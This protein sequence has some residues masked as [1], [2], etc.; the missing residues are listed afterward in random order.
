MIRRFKTGANRDTDI[1]KLDFEGFLSPLVM[2]RFAEYMNKNRKL[3]D[4]SIRDSDN[5]QLGIPKSAYMKSGFRH[6]FDWWKEHRGYKSRE[7][8]EEAICG[9]IFNAQGYLHEHLKEKRNLDKVI[10]QGLKGLRN[11]INGE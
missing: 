11:K 5:W 1:G 2:E 9:L 3:K 4:G 8:L 10:I 7:N 6:L